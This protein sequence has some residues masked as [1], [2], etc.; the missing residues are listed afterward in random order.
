ML[1]KIRTCVLL[2]L[3]TSVLFLAANEHL[4]A[5]SDYILEV[6]QHWETYGVGGTCIPGTHNLFVADVDDDSVVEIVTGGL[7][8]WV[9][10]GTRT[11]F[12]APLRIWSCAGQNLTLEKSMN[13]AG[14]IGCVYACDADSDGITEFITAGGITK[15]NGS[16]AQL[17][18]WHWDG[19]SLILRASYEGEDTAGTSISS[20]S[21]SDADGEGTSDIVTVG[22]FVNGNQSVAQLRVWHWNGNNLALNKSIEWCAVEQANAASVCS[23]D[24][25]NDGMIEIVTGGYDNDLKN[26]SGQLRIWRLN[27]TN[28]SL[29]VD[30]EWRLVEG[31]YGLNIAGG[32]QGNTVVNNVKVGDV[33]HDGVHE[34]VTGGFVYDGEKTNAQ[35]RIWTWNGQ[36]LYLEKSQ[37]WKT[38][39]LTEVKAISLDD[40]DGDGR[41]DIVT[42]GTT[43]SQNSFEENASNPEFAQLRVWSW[44]GTAL[45]LKY[46]YD[47]TIGEGV[48]AW[49]VATGDVDNDGITE[50]VTVG[51]M[52]VGN[53]CDPDLRIWSVAVESGPS[54]HYYLLVI[55]SIASMV[56]VVAAFVV[57]RQRR[58]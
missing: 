5:Q 54:T 22:R 19:Q 35:L 21:V 9:R 18:V 43:A 1:T 20:V 49:N 37:E 41:T 39:Y 48:C 29:L 51:C 13:W 42:S 36:T 2:V 28:L 23:L 38:E 30:E 3:L 14:R 33:D 26:S 4:S 53:L 27:G 16:Y 52:Y 6:E 58:K 12:E 15:N 11:D 31:V 55:A 17:R 7:M 50:I 24:L 45:T 47:W 44:D 46:S 32:V 57:L 40:V 8:Y 10:N 34:V 56:I 25:N